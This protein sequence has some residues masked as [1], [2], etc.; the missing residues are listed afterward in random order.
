[1]PTKLQSW[2]GMK[3]ETFEVGLWTVWIE[4]ELNVKYFSWF[5]L[6][7]EASFWN[8]GFCCFLCEQSYPV[9]TDYLKSGIY[10]WVGDAH[11][12]NEIPRHERGPH[13]ELVTSPNNPD[14]F[15][16]EQVVEGNDG[17]LVYDLAY[18]WPQYSPITSSFDAGIMLFTASKSTGHAGTRIG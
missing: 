11:A 6:I 4:N 16:R 18:Y 9:V 7:K 3:L 2:K 15:K 14:G 8:P 5:L 10:K 1:M 13:I 17:K 12:F